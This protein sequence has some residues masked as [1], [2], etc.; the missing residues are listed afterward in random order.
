ME[1][2]YSQHSQLAGLYGQMWSLAASPHGGRAQ[3]ARCRDQPA[4]EE[5]ELTPPPPV[6]PSVQEAGTVGGQ[7]GWST[8]DSLIEIPHPSKMFS[9]GGISIFYQKSGQLEHLQTAPAES[10]MFSYLS[11]S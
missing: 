7:S 4:E 5:A 11:S 1:D 6:W 3:R 9:F 10:F 8:N 2:M